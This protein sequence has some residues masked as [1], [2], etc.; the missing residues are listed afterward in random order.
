MYVPVVC[1]RYESARARSI[2][3]GLGTPLN[4]IMQFQQWNGML[5]R[6]STWNKGGLTGGDCDG[7]CPWFVQLSIQYPGVSIL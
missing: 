7:L 4:L 6:R 3:L 5:R 1:V 2:E